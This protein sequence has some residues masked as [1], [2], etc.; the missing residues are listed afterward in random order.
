MNMKKV[1]LLLI[2]LVLVFACT[3]VAGA[4][5]KGDP[6]PHTIADCKEIVSDF[7]GRIISLGTC[8]EDGELALCNHKGKNADGVEISE[9]GHFRVAHPYVLEQVDPTKF[10]CLEKVEMQEVCPVCGDKGR[11]TKNTE[12]KDHVF[13]DQKFYDADGC[14]EEPNCTYP[15][16]WYEVCKVCGTRSQL[17]KGEVLNPGLHNWTDWKTETEPTGCEY[18][19]APMGIEIRACGWCT[20]VSAVT[21]GSPARLT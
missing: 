17:K 5:E 6:C 13:D 7:D 11:V 19:G 14:W 20:K 3:A 15:E 12:L 9:E 2:A 18:S 8:K 10:P 16:T 21:P 1:A 4:L